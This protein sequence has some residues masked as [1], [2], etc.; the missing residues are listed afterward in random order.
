MRWPAYK[1]LYYDREFQVH[2]CSVEFL[3]V[4]LAVALTEYPFC[5]ATGLLPF[6]EDWRFVV[7]GGLEADTSETVGY[8]PTVRVTPPGITVPRLALVSQGL[9]GLVDY[10]VSRDFQVVGDVSRRST[11]R[12][13]LV[14][15]L[16]ELARLK[17]PNLLLE[18]ITRMA[19][20][21]LE[22]FLSFFKMDFRTGVRPYQDNGTRW[23][24]MV[25]VRS[26][27]GK[28]LYKQTFQVLG[29]VE[30]PRSC[31]AFVDDSPSLVVF[32]LEGWSYF[33]TVGEFL[34]R[35]EGLFQDATLYG[36]F[37]YSPGALSHLEARAV[38]RLPSYRGV[39]ELGE[40]EIQ[41]PPRGIPVMGY[42]LD[43]RSPIPIPE[44]LPVILDGKEALSI[45][46]RTVG[47]YYGEDVPPSF[48][49]N[50]WANYLDEEKETWVVLA[51]P[52]LRV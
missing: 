43:T 24:L 22:R 15:E 41:P 18:H 7:E 21:R 32:D 37:P 1:E 28:F 23:F 11:G 44:A 14:L 4:P 38:I 33:P 26:V 13:R 17:N 46:S 49:V 8:Y 20:I 35:F 9:H 12:D 48:K 16:L 50:L 10:L 6:P 36:T 3:E 42:L 47:I 31:F 52:K 39:R 34:H 27:G 19:Q 5:R 40:P 25:E 45:L 2:L 51:V 30:I 29:G